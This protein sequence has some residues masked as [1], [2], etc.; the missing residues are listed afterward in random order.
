MNN[1]N[2]PQMPRFT[3]PP[4]G[5]CSYSTQYDMV[6]QLMA[7]SGGT[8][9]MLN[10]PVPSELVEGLIKET[11]EAL[12]IVKKTLEA[13]KTAE[14][15]ADLKTMTEAACA[16][17]TLSMLGMSINGT[18]GVPHDLVFQSMIVHQH[19]QLKKQPVNFPVPMQVI[20]EVRAQAVEVAKAREQEMQAANQ[21]QL[22]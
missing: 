4:S 7:D 22:Q 5:R 2:T 13:V 17:A 1:P 21:Q 20:E 16:A 14:G 18:F 12:E 15:H 9:G 11:E 3:I 10:A 8:L 6:R 19:A